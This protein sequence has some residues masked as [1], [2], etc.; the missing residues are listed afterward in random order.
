MKTKNLF[1]KLKNRI[2]SSIKINASVEVLIFNIRIISHPADK[3]GT[4]Y[5][6]YLL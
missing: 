4:I 6:I 5:Y 2:K 1:T 3:K